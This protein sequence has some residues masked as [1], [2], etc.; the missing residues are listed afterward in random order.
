MPETIPPDLLA[1]LAEFDSP[2]VSNAVELFDT[3]DHVDGFASLELRCLTP[4]QRPTVGYAVTAT[5]DTTRPPQVAPGIPKVLA[6]RAL[7]TK[8][9]RKPSKRYGYGPPN[10]QIDRAEILGNGNILDPL[11]SAK[12]QNA[13]ARKVAE[14]AGCPL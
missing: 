12:R 4:G 13:H 10:L 9:S 6:S 3:R 5:A 11:A 7:R 8:E 2:T 14:V 1:A